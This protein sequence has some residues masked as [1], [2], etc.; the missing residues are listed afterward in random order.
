MHCATSQAVIRARICGRC[1]GFVKVTVIPAPRIEINR[2]DDGRKRTL[3]IQSSFDQAA[4][5][6]CS[7][8]ALERQEDKIYWDKISAYKDELAST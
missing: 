1:G 5:H 7:C 6:T 8:C 2:F 3:A 4:F